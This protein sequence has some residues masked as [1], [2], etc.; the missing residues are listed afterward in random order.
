MKIAIVPQPGVIKFTSSGYNKRMYHL[1]VELEKLGHQ[2]KIF[3]LPKSRTRGRLDASIN[4]GRRPYVYSWETRQHFISEAIKRSADCD[5]IN[6]QTD[7]VAV[8]FDKFITKPILH[9]LITSN[10]PKNAQRLLSFYKKHNYSA[11]SGAP[12]KQFKFLKFKGVVYNGCDTKS[13]RFNPGP[14]DYFLSLS[15][16]HPDK[17]IHRAVEAARQT[18]IKLYIAGKIDHQDYFEKKIKPHLGKKIKYLGF[19]QPSGFRGK[20]DL[21]QNAKCVF[22]LS[23]KD[24]GF[25]NTILESLSCGTPVIAWDHYSYREI[26]KNNK[27]GFIVKDMST[28][29]RAIKNIDKIDRAYCRQVIE[30][31]YTYEHMARGYEELFKKIIKK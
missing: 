6:C 8:M 13:F 21:I 5:I 9:T 23:E 14:K 26:I 29:K 2:V 31:N 22:S 10:L 20:I 24:E 4:F 16:I 19:I 28:I 30:K 11:V 7:H 15:R 27:T 3:A 18:R 1:V 12:K 17:G 25:S